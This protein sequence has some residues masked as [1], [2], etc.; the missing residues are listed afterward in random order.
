MK[1][2]MLIVNPS[3]GRGGY[4][5]YFGEAMKTLADGGFRTE[6]FFTGGPEDATEFAR[7]YAAE[8]DAV[9]CIGGDG[10]LSEVIG[11]L[12][13]I[14][15]PPPIGYIPMGTTNDVA[16]TIGLPKNDTIG[17]ARRIVEGTPHPFDVGGFGKDRYFAY[18]AAFGAFTEVSYATPQ[19]QKRALGHLAYVLQG[20]QQLG[21]IEKLPVRVEYDDGVFEGELVY[22][23]MSNSTS[24]AGIVR[25]RDEMVSLGD[26]M[27]EL[28]LV[29]DP[30]TIDAYGEMIT[31][32]LTRSFDSKYLKVIQTRHARF[33][34]D[35]PVAWT[36]DGE[37]GGKHRELELCNYHAP[38]RLIF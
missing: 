36:R 18:I 24:V 25:L 11:G 15:N 21:K 28:V 23:S 10:T 31:A 38:V 32:V 33:I 26:G 3:A 19:D 6:L 7:A 1:K 35:R 9:A 13:K 37:D 8:F 5:Y 34:F 4:R 27:S 2:L 16:S 30:G 12:M 22:G 14:P 20:A 29:Q 17:A